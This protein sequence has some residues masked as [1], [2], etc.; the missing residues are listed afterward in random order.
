MLRTRETQQPIDALVSYRVLNQIVA[1]A[2]VDPPF[3]QCLLADPDGATRGCPLTAEDQAMVAALTA[4][5]LYAWAGERLIHQ[6]LPI[7]A[8]QRFTIIPPHYTATP[9]PDQIVLIPDATFGNGTHDTTRLSLSALE[10]HMRPGD[11][12]LDLGTGSGIL[13]IAAVRLGAAS[14]VGL[15]I[16]AAAVKAA[17]HN[18]ALNGVEAR[19]RLGVGS[20]A[21]VG[22][23]QFDVV[24]GNILTDVLLDMLREGLSEV[25]RPGGVLILNGVLCRE[26]S[27]IEAALRRARL[28][29]EGRGTLGSWICHIARRRKRWL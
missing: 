1:R 11:G 10:R 29:V 3:R 18:A 8:S 15:D 9:T 12:M 23:R 22:A 13:A 27:L 24:V 28:A 14:V 16:N 21:E 25:V 17:Q 2:V 5:Q 19:V 7:R 20:L 6:V 26:A 4:E